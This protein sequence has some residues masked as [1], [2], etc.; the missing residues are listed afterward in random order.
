MRSLREP[1]RPGAYYPMS[2]IYPPSGVLHIRTAGGALPA[3]AIRN[4][5]AAVDPELPVTGIQQL[6]AGMTASM[7][8]TRTV[9]Y[10]IGGFALLALA[11]ASVGLY[12]LVSYGASQRVREMG[13]RIALGARPASLV[14][15]IL[16]RAFGIAL[17]GTAIGV[18]L[19]LLLGRALEGLLFG[20]APADSGALGGA[21]LL[22]LLTVGAA[23][24]VPAR[25]ASRVD[26]SVSLRG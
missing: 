26:A 18:G 17:I 19:S 2:L 15:L 23:A 20:V 4:A 5:V 7:G 10:L 3:D 14:R 24:W 22:L 12:G 25:R 9:A 6:T 11:L 16:T 8:E 13:V 1:G 21:A